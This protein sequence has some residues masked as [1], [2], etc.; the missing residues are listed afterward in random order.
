MIAVAKNAIKANDSSAIITTNVSGYPMNDA[1]IQKWYQ[2]FDGLKDNL[3]LLSVDMYPT[4]D[5]IEIAKL[6][7]RVDDLKTRYAKDVAVA[8]TGTCTIPGTYT[9]AD[10][11]N[12]IT[13]S[14]NSLKLSTAK[15]IILYEIMDEST[16]SGLC[17]GTF[18]ILHTDGTIK[19]SFDSVMA[20]MHPFAT[21]TP[22]STSPSP[23]PTLASTSTPLP[24]EIPT[25]VPTA[26]P[27][28]TLIPT[29]TPTRAP[30][31]TPTPTNIPTNTP[32]PTAVQ[33]TGFK[34][35]YY[36]N[37]SL[38]GVPSLVRNDNTINFNWRSG[39]P[40]PKINS[41]V[42]SVR[43]NKNQT[44]SSG[45]YRFTVSN[46]DGMRIYIDGINV[47][48][49]WKDQGASTKSFTKYMSQ[50]SHSIIIQ[51]YEN[52]GQAVAKFSWTK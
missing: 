47:Y 26:T 6:G 4:P 40:D 15:L 21:T 28:R 14:V 25:S 43:W 32:T 18:G 8:E 11:E 46:D 22:T 45:Y 29:A 33:F 13:K 2:Y 50:G 34:G 48:N 31:S 23:T 49:S 12:Y 42:F 30:T 44:F 16:S 7:S 37:A 38:I 19:S 36:N 10:Q 27:T 52:R 9:E 5:L 17:E 35:E 39:S 3:D 24:T 1:T 51:Y 20:S 41:D